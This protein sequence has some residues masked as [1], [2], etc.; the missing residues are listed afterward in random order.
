MDYRDSDLGVD[1]KDKAWAQHWFDTHLPDVSRETWGQLE[2]Y[3]TLLL[4]A[5]QSQ[6]LIAAST[7]ANIWSR[8]IVDSLQLLLHVPAAYRDLPWLDVGTGAGLPAIPIALCRTGPMHMIE[9][10]A[11]RCCFLRDAVADLGISDRAFVHEMPISRCNLPP[12]GIISARAFAPLP[13]LVALTHRFSH[14]GTVWVLPK[15]KNAATEVTMMPKSLQTMFH[16]KPSIT[17]AAAYILVAKGQLGTAKLTKSNARPQ[18]FR[19]ARQG[20][21]S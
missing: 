18:R 14:A 16:V 6:N 1:P 5:A 17:D 3:V 13:K 20:S 10:R 19:K 12:V 7:M 15:G 4:A 9:S 21:A 8:H 11:L 2:A